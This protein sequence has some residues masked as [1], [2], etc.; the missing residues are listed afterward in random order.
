M[1]DTN[2]QITTKVLQSISQKKNHELNRAKKKT[3]SLSSSPWV[4]A[5][6]CLALPLL[7]SKCS[8]AAPPCRC[9]SSPRA[10]PL[11]LSAA[12]PASGVFVSFSQSG[13]RLGFRPATAP[14]GAG[15]LAGRASLSPST[16]AVLSKHGLLLL[17]PPHTDCGFTTA[18]SM[19]GRWPAWRQRRW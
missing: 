6:P 2:Y 15:S 4:A 19:M 16:P 8:A 17:E 3:S 14:P 5:A 1:I 11:L 13:G 9:S 18:T 10:V 12:G 7:P